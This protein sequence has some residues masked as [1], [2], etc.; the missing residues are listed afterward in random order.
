MAKLSV[1]TYLAVNHFY[2]GSGLR[3]LLASGQTS[4]R[5]FISISRFSPDRL[6]PDQRLKTDEQLV[7]SNGRLT[8]KVE[9]DGNVS[10][11]RSMFGTRLWSTDS[12]SPPAAD[13]VMQADGNLAARSSDRT[14]VWTSGTVGN[15]GASCILQDDGNLVIDSS[16]GTTLWDTDTVQDFLSPAYVYQAAD[17]RTYDETSESWKE[18]CQAF[19][20]FDA[21]QWPDYATT[22]VDTTI[23]GQAVV[24][25]LWK[26]WCPKFVGLSN[27]PGGVG[28]EVG[29]YRR[30]PGRARPTSIPFLPPALESLILNSMTTL[31]DDELWWP[32]PELGATVE[33]TLIN[34]I[35]QE[36]FFSAGPEN[37]YWLAKWMFDDSYAH[38][39][40][41]QGPGRTPTFSTGYTLQYRVNGADQPAW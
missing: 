11:F 8:L 31:T 16:A 30:I 1:R 41:A 13:L 9:T 34:P 12:T 17:S 37:T 27:F 39:Q 23:N 5:K 3:H 32:F 6:M 36:P 18:L 10:L 38:Y 24:I 15:A 25:Q 4:V 35:T 21:L 7:S 19:P 20:C 2:V 40:A 14:P 22:H 28:A 33:Y 29:I 26:G